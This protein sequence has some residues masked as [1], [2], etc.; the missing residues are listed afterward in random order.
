MAAGYWLALIPTFAALL[1]AI[2]TLVR[3]IRR[4]APENFMLLSLFYLALYALVSIS[5]DMPASALMKAF[6]GLPALVPFCAFVATGCDALWKWCGKC[7]AIPIVAFSIW[8]LNSFATFWI[9]RASAAAEV[10]RPWSLY[11]EGQD[12]EAQRLL[13]A[14]IK[15]DPGTEDAHWV[16]ALIAMKHRD[17]AR[18]AEHAQAI[19]RVRPNSPAG[20]LAMALALDNQGKAEEAKVHARAVIQSAP[21]E[22][23][24][25]GLLARLR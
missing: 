4:P 12:A 17:Y 14:R 1:G 9:V 10:S 22:L 16:S 8:A 25:Y 20:H 23:K 21:G 11:R 3:F 2:L 13:D 5:L 19:L 7:R 6:Y 18:A 24:A 15:R